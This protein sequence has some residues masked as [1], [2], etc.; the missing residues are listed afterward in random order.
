MAGSGEHRD[1]ER[2]ERQGRQLVELIGYA[3]KLPRGTCTGKAT[4]RPREP[5]PRPLGGV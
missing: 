5:L 4:A 1:L 3:R 2:I